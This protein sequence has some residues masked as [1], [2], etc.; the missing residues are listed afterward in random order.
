MG[1][2]GKLLELLKTLLGLNDFEYGS[3]IVS[4][5]QPSASTS[6]RQE[7]LVETSGQPI[8][9]WIAASPC[10]NIPAC[11]GDVDF[12]SEPQIVPNGFIINVIVNSG[13]CKIDWF[14]VE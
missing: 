6:C 3:L 2:I 7:I 8:K 1:V 13:C 11:G 12:V 5:C 9:V 10:G 4:P 14:V